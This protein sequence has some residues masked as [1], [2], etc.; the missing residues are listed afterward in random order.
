MTKAVVIG[1]GIGG[2]SAALRLRNKGYT[3]HVFESNPYPGGKIHAI[4]MKGFR[5]DMG[6]SLFTMPHLIDQ[7]FELFGKK[8]EDHFNY[9]RKSILCRYFWEDGTRFTAKDGSGEFAKEAADVFGVEESTI[10]K[11]LNRN[12]SK[13]DLTATLFLEKSLHRWTSYLSTRTLRALFFL[14]RLDVFQTLDQVNRRSFSEQKLVQLFNRYATYN[15]S[16][17]YSTPGIMSMIPHLEMFFGTFFPEG[18]MHQIVQSL[19]QLAL[20][21]GIEFHFN[22]KVDEILVA[23]RKAKDRKSV[24]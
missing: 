13:F 6:P 17:P 19:Y 16:S 5:F 10:L 21:E 8:P 4:E 7:L 3:V 11:Y 1:A 22:N 24:V 18:G 15:G 2:I 9:K 20:E 12:K 23:D 14:G